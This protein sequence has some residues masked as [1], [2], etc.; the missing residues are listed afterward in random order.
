MHEERLCAHQKLN[1]ANEKR[2]VGKA[3]TTDPPLLV[4][5]RAFAVTQEPSAEPMAS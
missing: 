1:N 5:L 3:L 4:D 2:N